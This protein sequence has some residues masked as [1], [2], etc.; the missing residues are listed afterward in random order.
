MGGVRWGFLL[1]TLFLS[2]HSVQTAYAWA[3]PEEP[4]TIQAPEGGAA[5]SSCAHSLLWRVAFYPIVPE[6]ASG[7]VKKVMKHGM[8]AAFYPLYFLSKG[9]YHLASGMWKGEK[10]TQTTK[11]FVTS[12]RKDLLHMV[13][14]SGIFLASHGSAV[15]T[16]Q[17]DRRADAVETANTVTV[18]VNGFPKK[19]PLYKY[20]KD[21]FD[22]R[23]RSN[24]NA[25]YVEVS[26]NPME[27]LIPLVDISKKAGPVKVLKLYGHGSSGVIDVGALSLSRDS[28]TFRDWQVEAYHAER[29]GVGQGNSIHTEVKRP[30]PTL[31]NEYIVDIRDEL[32]LKGVMDKD[33]FILVYGCHTAEGEAGDKF[34][35][36]LGVVFADEG[37]T[38]VG[39]T[40][41]VEKNYTDQLFGYYGWNMSH[42]PNWMHQGLDASFSSV[43]LLARAINRFTPAADQNENSPSSFLSFQKIKERKVGPR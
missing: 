36:Y 42:I 20:V 30:H 3:E 34:L 12:L 28:L 1:F 15:S 26:N 7:W 33:S 23:Y 27:Y 41:N 17:I 24:P 13:L 35:D 18:V 25:F 16:W 14:F 5:K 9:A 10:I 29:I 32:R 22:V 37:A 2:I 6:K 11:S 8:K 39:S 38:V 43:D 21:Q 19:D 40:V 4:E 31:E